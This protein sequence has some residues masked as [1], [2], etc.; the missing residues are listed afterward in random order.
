MSVL[1]A[2]LAM[3]GFLWFRF[4]FSL[5]VKFDKLRNNKRPLYEGEANIGKKNKPRD[6]VHAIVEDSMGHDEKKLKEEL[7]KV[8][9]I[10][11]KA[12]GEVSLCLR[13]RLSGE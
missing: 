2:L 3:Q 6:R 13:P 11:M 1:P 4:T 9:E 8:S 12:W 7:Q 10:L 5:R